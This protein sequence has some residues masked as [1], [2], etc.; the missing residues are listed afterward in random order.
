MY[1]YEHVRMLVCTIQDRCKTFDEID[2][3]KNITPKTNAY[4]SPASFTTR[5]NTKN[6]TSN[7]INRKNQHKNQ[8]TAKKNSALL[9]LTS[10]ALFQMSFRFHFTSHSQISRVILL[11]YLNKARALMPPIWLTSRRYIG[12]GGKCAFIWS[13]KVFGE[14]FVFESRDYDG[15]REA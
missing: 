7:T 5:K 4:Q 9:I 13:D 10:G 6:L 11:L 15:T 2:L 8:T 3:V 12:A 1:M 14:K